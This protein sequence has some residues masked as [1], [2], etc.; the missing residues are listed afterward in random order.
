MQEESRAG[1]A[2]ASVRKTGR[3]LSRRSHRE[4][5]MGSGKSCLALLSGDLWVQGLVLDPQVPRSPWP[6]GSVAFCSL[7][8]SGILTR[9]PH[10]RS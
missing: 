1:S 4:E 2:A 3:G 9:T 10:S 6:V 5:L 7:L 8:L